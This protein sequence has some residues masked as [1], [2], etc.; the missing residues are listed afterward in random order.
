MALKPRF[1]FALPL[2]IALACPATAIGRP[3]PKLEDIATPAERRLVPLVRAAA[4]HHQESPETTLAEMDALLRQIPRPTPLRG[5]VQLARAMLLDALRN[6]PEARRAA[7]DAV[8]LLPDYAEPLFLAAHIE[9]YGDRIGDA[10]DF[11]LR[12]SMVDADTAKTVTDDYEMGNILRRLEDAGERARLGALSERFLVTGWS[13]GR[14]DTIS[15]MAVA[16]IRA[17]VD[18]GKAADAAPLVRRIADPEHLVP[19]MT[20]RRYQALWPAVEAWAGSRFEKLWPLY[21]GDARHAWETGQ[22]EESARTYLTALS[23]AG[24]D[25]ALIAEFLPRL[26]GAIGPEDTM[27]M[28]VDVDVASALARLGRWDEAY[29]VL[30]K[31]AR[32]WPI[33]M[34]A[35]SLNFSANRGRLLQLQ[36][37]FVDALAELD[38]AVADSA[39]WGAEVNSS[40]LS[41]MHLARACALEQLGRGRDDTLSSDSL[42]REKR[43]YP[44]RYASWRICAGDLEGARQALIEGLSEAKPREAVIEALQPSRDGE[45]PSDYSR[46]L[47]QRWVKLRSDPLLVAAVS[48]YA[49][50][51]VEPANASAPPD[52]TPPGP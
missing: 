2:A 29:R 12:A 8:R 13:R 20:E 26:A 28:F 42:T 43:P 18:A 21:L 46:T 45:Y 19:L 10:A 52:P 48:R 25:R 51:L 22:T 1:L 15:T 14:P 27:L 4:A 6:T 32:T 41:Q 39:R 31:G 17:R 40:A 44:V 35:A 3:L 47:Y 16:A 24:H 37:R 38:R 36:G 33:E 30:D 34:T 23:S 5:M 49:R 11:L 50:I 9:A 7:A